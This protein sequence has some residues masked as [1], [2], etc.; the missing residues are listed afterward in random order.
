MTSTVPGAPAWQHVASPRTPPGPDHPPTLWS[1]G[2]MKGR[3]VVLATIA[4]TLLVVALDLLMTGRLSFFFDVCLVPISLVAA[5]AVRPREFFW[6]AVLPPL[7]VL[8]TTL[9]VALL[10]PQALSGADDNVLQAA[11]VGLADRGEA[12]LW[13]Q[14]L[15]L[16][17]LAV[18]RR[19]L[20]LPALMPPAGKLPPPVDVQGDLVAAY[21]D[22]V[23][24]VGAE[25]LA[26]VDQ[27]NEADA[28]ANLSGSPAP[29]RSTSA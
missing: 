12:T 4:V 27:A 16:V 9:E 23:E 25:T 8:S 7:L 17:V 20:A 28:Q 22:A 14:G 5:L 15:T 2:R 11:I 1:E 13:A 21:D 3:D 24:A 6:V 18:R 26:A 10:A 19:V 29:T